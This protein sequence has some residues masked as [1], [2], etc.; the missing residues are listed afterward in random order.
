MFVVLQRVPPRAVSA[1]VGAD[2]GAVRG[3]HTVVRS[4]DHDVCSRCV[5]PDVAHPY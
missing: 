2:D 5:E 4:R 3:R 1:A